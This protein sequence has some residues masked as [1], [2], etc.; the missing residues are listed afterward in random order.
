M[1]AN[2]LSRTFEVLNYIAES[3]DGITYTEIGQAC[4]G[5]AIATLARLLKSMVQENLLQKASSGKYYL[6][7]AAISFAHKAVTLN[8]TEELI[9]PIV[10]KLAEAAEQ[11]AVYFEIDGDAAK[12]VSKKEWPGSMFYRQIG[13]RNERIFTHPSALTIL[14]FEKAN[15]ID[16]LL[17]AKKPKVAEKESFLTLLKEIREKGY[18]LG[19]DP[20]YPCSRAIY[21]VFQKG[22]I[23]GS[24]GVCMLGQNLDKNTLEKFSKTVKKYAELASDR[25]SMAKV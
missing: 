10:E 9:K 22:E 21:P 7:S 24:I 5:I 2:Q 15:M 23:K 25:L 1:S 14:A 17:K 16:F 13:A 18:F 11:S 4:E 8:S 6:G 12:I 3:K 19:N 20:G